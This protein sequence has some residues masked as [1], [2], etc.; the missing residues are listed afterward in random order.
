MDKL[1]EALNKAPN[2]VKWGGLAAAI[3]L[4]TAVNYFFFVSDA[5][6]RITQQQGEQRT[7]EQQLAEK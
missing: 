5:E 4:V 7:L 3:V 1:I 6:D 2:S